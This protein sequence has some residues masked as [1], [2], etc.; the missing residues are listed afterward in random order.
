M[1][2]PRTGKI[3]K[4]RGPEGSEEFCNFTSPRAL[5]N[6]L[7]PLFFR[8]NHIPERILEAYHSSKATLDFRYLFMKNSLPW[9]STYINLKLFG[10]NFI[11]R[12]KKSTVIFFSAKTFKPRSRSEYLKCFCIVIKN[13]L[14]IQNDG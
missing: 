8:S 5:Q 7:L 1:Q 12:R 4:F 14:P 2:S 10:G 3:A 6:L 13:F 11:F 9:Y